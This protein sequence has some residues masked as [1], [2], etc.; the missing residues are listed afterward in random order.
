MFLTTLVTAKSFY[1]CV[2]MPC[3]AMRHFAAALKSV[4]IL[5]RLDLYDNIKRE[6]K[7]KKNRNKKR[8]EAKR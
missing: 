4:T 2:P 3:V 5:R 1:K 6:I 7:D 8:I